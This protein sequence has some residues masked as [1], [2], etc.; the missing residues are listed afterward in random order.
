[1]AFNIRTSRHHAKAQKKS[2]AMISYHYRSAW[3]DATGVWKSLALASI[4]RHLQVLNSFVSIKKYTETLRVLIEAFLLGLISRW[5]FV[6]SEKSRYDILDLVWYS[7]VEFI[8]LKIHIVAESCRVSNP[9]PLCP[10]P[11]G[12]PDSGGLS[13]YASEATLSVQNKALF[14]NTKYSYWS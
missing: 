1:M 2:A 6:T 14:Q 12:V 4:L 13:S 5:L 7:E 3:F 9:H 11:R 8:S 10:D